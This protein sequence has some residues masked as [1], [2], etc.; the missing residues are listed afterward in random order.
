VAVQVNFS[1]NHFST[2]FRN[3]TGVTFRDYLAQMRIEQAKR[4]LVTSNLKCAE[5]AY[6]CGYN[7][8]HYFSLIFRRNCNQTPQQY[9][10]SNRQSLRRA[11][12]ASNA[13]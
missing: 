1:P 11:A 13:E 12:P 4:L 8:P 6:Q 3:E 10:A 7:D 9:R 5:V 2:V